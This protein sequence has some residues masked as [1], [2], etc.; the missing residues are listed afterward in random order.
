M[1]FRLNNFTCLNKNIFASR[2]KVI[3]IRVCLN[4]IFRYLTPRR[5]PTG[6][7]FFHFIFKLYFSTASSCLLTNTALKTWVSLNATLLNSLS[8][9]KLWSIT[10]NLDSSLFQ[11]KFGFPPFAVKVRSSFSTQ[12]SNI[13]KLNFNWS[14][15]LFSVSNFSSVTEGTCFDAK[16]KPPLS[17]L[18]AK[19]PV[20]F[21]KSTI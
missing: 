1:N 9:I 18:I 3:W 20:T 14:S 10:Y 19:P 15:I 13:N 6:K 17:P 2:I 4:P 8:K 7:T 16:T 11:S 12:R 5:R 21:N